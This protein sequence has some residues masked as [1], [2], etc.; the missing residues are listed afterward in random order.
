MEVTQDLNDWKMD[1]YESL[2][3]SLTLV[4][5]KE[6]DDQ[7]VWTLSANGKFI[8]RTFYKYLT[9]RE[10]VEGNFLFRQ[11]W[12]VNAS[13]RIVFFACEAFRGFILSIDELMRV[14]K[15]LVN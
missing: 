4:L 8:V 3:R 2:L 6:D 9:K 15:T 13:S 14:G 5:L 11:I 10:T 1:E 12:K 7:P